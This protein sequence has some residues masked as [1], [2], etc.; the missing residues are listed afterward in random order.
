MTTRPAI[1]VL[2]GPTASGKS[3]LAL[4]LAEL[5]D[6]EIVN[7]DS[8]Q[9]YRGLDVG[10]GKPTRADQARTPHH[11]YDLAAPWEQL[12]SARFA[13]LADE[14]IADVAARGRLPI[15]VGGTG[16]W[17][18]ALLR[19]LVDAPPRD[20]DVRLRLE[21]EATRDLGA[22]HARLAEVDP[23]SAARIH[24]TDPVRIVRALEVFELG[25][26][27]LSELHRRHASGAP[28]YPA[29]T[30]A[31]GPPMPVLEK[32]IEKRARAMFESGLVEETRVALQDPRAR[33]RL[34]RVMGY[35]EALGL[36]EGRLTPK[37]ALEETYR[38]QRQY[39]RRQF[40]WFRAEPQW[41]WLDP[42][43]SLAD[44][45]ARIDSFRRSGTPA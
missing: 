9:V 28:R 43:T 38:A 31:L 42:S 21:A 14:A 3:D 40:T 8:Q 27:P 17:I 11:L 5:F 12:D 44:A 13:T 34:S 20:P 36:I 35:R 33:E 39:A 19:G 2:A 41:A 7:A 26:V 22:L 45:R 16:L 15:L 4:E 24:R 10:T 32:R 23:E 25:G 37:R 18:R 6:G 1:V 29:L 30:L